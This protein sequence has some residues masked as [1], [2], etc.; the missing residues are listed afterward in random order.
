M[1][2]LE[3]DV[4]DQA[5]WDQHLEGLRGHGG[6]MVPVPASASLAL[7]ETVEVKVRFRA[8]DVGRAEGRVVQMAPDG[9]AAVLFEGDAKDSL[10]ALQLTASRGASTSAGGDQP[11]W[12]RYE[13]LTKPEK[14][15]L[16]RQGNAD[17]RR[18]ILRDPDQSLHGFLL[19]NPGVTAN[20][21]V[22][23]FRGGLVPR[24]L[25]DLILQRSELSSNLQIMEALVQ[26]PRTPIPAALKMVPRISMETCRRI[27]KAGKHRAQIVSAARKRVITK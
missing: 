20:E 26:D 21:V 1:A 18:R 17:V 25:I 19:S 24:N 7:F 10:E 6:L 8:R 15:K 4:V 5:D 16:A 14:I 23:W 11:L 2:T 27:A 9:R 13:T 3:L 22:G 12:A